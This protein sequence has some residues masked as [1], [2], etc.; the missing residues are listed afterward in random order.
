MTLA[1]VEQTLVCQDC[2]QPFVFSIAEQAFYAE[3]GFRQPARCAGCRARRRAERHAEVIKAL[4]SPCAV[5]WH[6]GFGNFGGGG[7]T[8]GN[9]RTRR[10]RRSAGPGFAYP[11]VCSACGRDTEVPFAPRHGRPVFCR[12]CFEA[13]RGR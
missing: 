7:A 11:A 2:E 10:D 8:N 13:R 12:D 6:E 9:G 5:A 3:R 4:D 1:L